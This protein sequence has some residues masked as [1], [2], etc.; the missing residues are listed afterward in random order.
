ML[1]LDD[2]VGEPSN[3]AFRGWS[4]SARAHVVHTI[5]GTFVRGRSSIAHKGVLLM[6]VSD[7]QFQI[8]HSG[9]PAKD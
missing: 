6:V 4:T 5:L 1:E 3:Y 2:A 8:G 7:I 9:V